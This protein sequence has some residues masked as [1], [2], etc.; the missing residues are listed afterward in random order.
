MV[1]NIVPDDGSLFR[2]TSGSLP[3]DHTLHQNVIFEIVTPF[4]GITVRTHIADD[5]VLRKQCAILVIVSP[6]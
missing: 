6:E 3:A 1:N 4:K 2:A 5:D